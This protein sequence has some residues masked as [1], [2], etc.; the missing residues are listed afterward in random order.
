MTTPSRRVLLV[1]HIGRPEAQQLAAEVAT[2]LLASGIGVVAPADELAAPRSVPSTGSRTSPRPLGHRPRPR[3][4]EGC[5]LVVVLGGDG[6]ILRGAELSRGSR[7]AAPRG[8]P[9][10]RRLPRRGRARGH[11]RHRRA[12][13]RPGLHR[14]GAHH[15]RGHRPRG[16]PRRLR[17]VGPQ[18]GHRREGLPR[19]D[20]RAHRRDRRPAAVHLGLRRRRHGH[21]HRLHRLRLLRRRSRRVAR[22]RGAARR[23]H[24]RARPLLPPGPR[25]PAV[26]DRGRGGPRHGGQRR[27]VVRRP[28]RRRPAPG[29]PH[30]G[31][32]QQPAGAA[33]PAVHRRLHRPARREVRPP[34]ARA[35]AV[36]PGGSRSR[37]DA[38]P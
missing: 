17:V 19:A 16:R 32:A 29:R 12:D 13:L 15:P 6:T 14:R 24:Q 11:R 18:R 38:A 26:A 21:A 37:G 7:G 35:G 4:R 20:A 33:G 1:T 30:R 27:R 23:P 9:R 31:P 3:R 36:R 5:E 2:R 22:R 28:P 25:R 10:P 34:G 8:Q